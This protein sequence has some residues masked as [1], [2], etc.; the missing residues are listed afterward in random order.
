[1]RS[2]IHITGC[3]SLRTSMT[4]RPVLLSTS[5]SNNTSLC[6]CPQIPLTAA[7]ILPLTTFD[8]K[9]LY[10]VSSLSWVVCVG[11]DRFSA[12][13]SEQRLAYC[14]I[15]HRSSRRIILQWILYDLNIPVF[16]CRITPMNTMGSS[17][18]QRRSLAQR[19]YSSRHYTNHRF[20]APWGARYVDPVWLTSSR[21]R[22]FHTFHIRLPCSCDNRCYDESDHHTPARSGG[23][24][25]MARPLPVMIPP[26]CGP[27]DISG[28][29]AVHLAAARPCLLEVVYL[30]ILSTIPPLH[31]LH[32]HP[33]SH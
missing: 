31:L 18:L 14:P 11:Q 5:T 4:G 30:F 24:P 29:P 28:S 2:G 25:Q 21:H 17:V 19:N 33:Y 32:V 1:M 9:V 8:L 7:H 20:I 16:V 3:F 22:T 26:P 13:V 27:H 6:P 12:T 10:S 23:P 15:S